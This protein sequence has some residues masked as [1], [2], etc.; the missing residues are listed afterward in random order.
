MTLALG[1]HAADEFHFDFVPQYNA[2]LAGLHARWEWLPLAPL[3][4]T[5]LIVGL[6]FSTAA[7]LALVPW[8]GPDRSWA[9]LVSVNFALIM[10]ANGIGHLLFSLLA[11]RALAGAWTSLLM[12][13][14]A[15]WLLAVEWRHPAGD[16]RT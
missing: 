15:G 13:A 6:L 8:I 9:R 4:P 5:A 1:I 2:A 3:H 10:A 12:V 11:G 16:L 14:A 7:L